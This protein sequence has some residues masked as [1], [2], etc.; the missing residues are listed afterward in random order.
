VAG[1]PIQ[2]VDVLADFPDLRAGVEAGDLDEKFAAELAA[3]RR[4][5]SRTRT[6]TSTREAADQA[7]KQMEQRQATAREGLDALG[8]QLSKSDVDYSRKLEIMEK[9]GVIGDIVANVPPERWQQAFR[10]AYDALSDVASSMR[11]PAPKPGEQPMR[12]SGKS[13]SGAEAQPKTVKDAV[14]MA[15]AEE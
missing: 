1:V 5:Q 11:Q 9:R 10:S 14:R 13:G 4:A 2:G 15:I 6:E 8:K 12:R 3:G 7:T